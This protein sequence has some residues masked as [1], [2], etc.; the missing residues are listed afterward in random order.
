MIERLWAGWRTDYVGGREPVPAGEG[1]L[2]ER[3]FSSGLPDEQT[4][5]LWR[6]ERSAALLNAYP[7]TT[8]HVLVLPLRAVEQLD[9][10]TD[11][12]ANELWLGVRL[13]VK[14][15]RAAYQPDGVNVGANLGKAAGAGIPEHL[16]VHVVP[17]WFGDTNFTT[18]IAETR[19]LPESLATTWTKLGH[20]WPNG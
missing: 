9:E 11:D 5:M 12:E 14:A 18:S 6:G 4:F 16:H 1:S 17:R 20:S 7:Y 2:F 3:I 13:A 10:L 15:V 19:V 8:G